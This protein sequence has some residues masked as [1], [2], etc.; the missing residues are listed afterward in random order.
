MRHLA[1]ED[2]K[3]SNRTLIPKGSSIVVSSHKM[4][5]PA[6]YANPETL[7]HEAPAQLVSPS[8]A[9]LGFGYGKHACPG[10]FF[11]ANEIKIVLCHIL[12][13]YDKLA[14]GCKLTVRKNGF[15]LNSDPL[16]KLVIRRRQEEIAL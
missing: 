16:E 9:H 11:A 4:W 7:G 3:L 14:D 15:S 5:N 12:L 1:H 13:K 2:I 10:R 8:P 6:D